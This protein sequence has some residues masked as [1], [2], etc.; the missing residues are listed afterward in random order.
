MHEN[1]PDWYK[2]HIFDNSKMELIKLKSNFNIKMTSAL[3]EK[4]KFNELYQLVKQEL[5]N[6]QLN[7]INVN[8]TTSNRKLEREKWLRHVECPNCG[9]KTNIHKKDKRKRKAGY[10][11]RF[12]CN[13]CNSM[14]Q[15]ELDKL[16]KMIQEYKE[17]NK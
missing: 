16:E 9:E 11:Q 14:F 15:I 4:N 7:N 12:Y 3:F 8:K 10:I 6:Y 5:E 1:I 13:E 2:I 17:D